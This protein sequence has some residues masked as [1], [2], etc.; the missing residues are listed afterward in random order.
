MALGALHLHLAAT[1]TSATLYLLASAAPTLGLGVA[2]MS[3][4]ALVGLGG[5]RCGHRKC[6]DT[7]CKD[8][9]PHH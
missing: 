8:E 3:S 1:T 9:L 5:C 4:V 7:G 6:R 2:T